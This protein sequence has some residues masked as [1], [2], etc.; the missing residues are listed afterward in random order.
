MARRVTL[1]KIARQSGVSLTTVSLVL[2]EKRGVNIETRRK[3]LD[4]AR[5]LGYPLKMAA[6][7]APVA[8][9]QHIGVVMRTRAYDQPQTNLFYTPV[10]MGIEAACRKQNINMLYGSMTVD[11]E[12]HPVELPRML[13][14][15]GL[16]GLI[17]V[18]AF[19]DAEIAQIMQNSGLPIV[20][21]DSYALDYNYDAVLTDNFQ[22]AYQAVSYLIARGHRRIGIVGSHP[23]GFP[24]VVERR[25]GYLQALQDHGIVQPYFADSL[26]I[27]S[28]AAAAAVKLIQRSPEVTALFCCNDDV[29]IGVIQSTQAAGRRVPDDISVIGFDDIELAEHVFPPITTMRVDKVN[30]GRL[31]VQTLSNHV[32]FLASTHMSIALK[33][34]LI[35]RQSV[36]SVS[37]NCSREQ[38]R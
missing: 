12:N 27:R 25:R 6:N 23:Q 15:D 28:E 31:A 24:S 33:P 38:N 18:G 4:V 3:V 8:S 2:R 20:L 21:V 10:L 22:G 9:L 32:E 7:G 16:D 13:Q 26:L 11:M 19:V 37:E 34:V 36:A 35:E 17:V 1:E 29:A 5:Q 30:M 14:E